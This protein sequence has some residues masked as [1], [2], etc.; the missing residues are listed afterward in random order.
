VSRITPAFLGVKNVYRASQHEEVLGVDDHAIPCGEF[1]LLGEGSRLWVAP[2]KVED[3]EFQFAIHRRTFP[4]PPPRNPA[5]TR[6][7][8]WRSAFRG[9]A[10]RSMTIPRL[11]AWCERLNASQK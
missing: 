4:N 9:I 8:S 3:L 1:D 10:E 6:V 7:A 5:M 2:V 11:I